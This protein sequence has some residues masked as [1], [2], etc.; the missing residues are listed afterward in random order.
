MEAPQSRP[1]N[2]IRKKMVLFQTA[3]TSAKRKKSVA[4]AAWSSL[5]VSVNQ[6]EPLNYI[7]HKI[8]NGL[9]CSKAS[10]GVS[11]RLQLVLSYCE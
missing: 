2:A 10:I 1:K 8:L 3:G 6:A 5:Q 7:L 11:P 4:R 9:R